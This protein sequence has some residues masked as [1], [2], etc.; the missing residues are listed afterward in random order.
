MM[1]ATIGQLGSTVPPYTTTPTIMMYVLVVMA[2]TFGYLVGVNNHAS[3]PSANIG[4]GDVINS[5]SYATAN[6]LNNNTTII[7]I[8]DKHPKYIF[9]LGE[10]NSGT[11]YLDDVLK[12]FIQSI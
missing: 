4:G 11:N 3:I 5:S 7:T 2:A 8:P 10:R 1:M 6:I 12:L 9:L